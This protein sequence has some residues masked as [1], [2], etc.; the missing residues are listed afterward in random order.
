MTTGE[1]TNKEPTDKEPKG[2]EKAHKR[3][4]FTLIGGVGAC[5][6]TLIGHVLIREWYSPDV[7]YEEGAYY[8]SGQEAIVSLKLH[9]YGGDGAKDIKISATFPKPLILLCQVI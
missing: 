5:I 9:N 6:L 1:P 2:M 4:L 7:R 8:R 3:G